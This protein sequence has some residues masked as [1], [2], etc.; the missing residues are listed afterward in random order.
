MIPAYSKISSENSLEIFMMKLY[1]RM[2]CTTRRLRSRRL[3]LCL[4]KVLVSSKHMP[5]S[6]KGLGWAQLG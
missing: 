5:W 1:C 6:M 3:I 2:D 4:L